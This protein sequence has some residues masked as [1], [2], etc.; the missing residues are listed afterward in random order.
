MKI[1]L[2]SDLHIDFLPDFGKS[3]L[4]KI[5]N[6]EVDILVV[7]GDLAPI[8]HPAFEKGLI[9]LTSYYPI[10]IIVLGNHEYYYSSP[11]EVERITTY[12]QKLIPNF[13][14]LENQT[15]ELSGITFAGTTLWYKRTPEACKQETTKKQFQIISSFNPWVYQQNQAAREFLVTVDADIIITHH[16]PSSKSVEPKYKND[17]NC[18]YVCDVEDIIH[19]NQ[20]KYWL[21]GHTHINCNYQIG[22]TRVIANPYGY[23][24]ESNSGFIEQLI[25]EVN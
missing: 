24:H 18:F 16:L 15:I 23:P 6:S 9:E 21:H 10:V 20:P 8:N 25:L 17:S 13:Y 12:L 19:T 4:N 2:I 11:Q 22:N 3:L 5:K 1:Q 7:A 14:I